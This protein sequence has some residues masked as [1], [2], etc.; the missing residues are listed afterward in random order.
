MTKPLN[1][2]KMS[3]M[4][5]NRLGINTAEAIVLAEMTKGY[6]YAFQELG[7]LFFNHKYTKPEQAERE[8]RAELY[9]Y[10]YEKIWEELS[11]GDREIV[12]IIADRE[13]YKREE[14]IGKMSKP[15][16]YSVYR[17]RLT[18]RGITQV[19]QGFIGLALPYFGD[20]VR[21]Y[22]R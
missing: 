19:R 15:Q 8:L 10:A 22:H 13:E 6:A 4:Y 11:D 20:Y 1:F 16:N 7:V 3:E 9:A 2:I 21:E 17:D 12:R 18:R 14:V 5:R